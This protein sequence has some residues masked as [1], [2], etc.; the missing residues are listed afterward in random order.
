MREHNSK[1]RNRN[2][3]EIFYRAGFI[4]SWGRGIDKIISGIEGSGLPRPKFE[5]DCGGIRVTFSRNICLQKGC[6]AN[7][8]GQ[9]SSQGIL[10]EVSDQ[11]SDQVGRVLNLCKNAA[12]LAQIGKVFTMSSRIYIKRKYVNPLLESGLLEMTIPDKPTSSQQKYRTTAKGLQL[13]ETRCGKL[14]AGEK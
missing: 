8:N 14:S 11:V 4:E 6:T 2:I 1:P 3:A 5:Y 9:S 10:S 13:L 12:T 7:K